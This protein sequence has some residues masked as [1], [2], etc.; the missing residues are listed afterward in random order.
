MVKLAAYGVGRVVEACI[1]LHG[2]GQRHVVLCVE[3]C[4][5]GK[6]VGLSQ[7]LAVG[8]VPR[9]LAHAHHLGAEGMVRVG[10]AHAH[11]VLWGGAVVQLGLS[12]EVKDARLHVQLCLV[13]LSLNLVQ[14]VKSHANLVAVLGVVD[15]CV[16]KHLGRDDVVPPCCRDDVAPLPSQL[17]VAAVVLVVRLVDGEV[18]LVVARVVAQ[19]QAVAVA[20]LMVHLHVQVV[21]V[22]ARPIV[23]VVPFNMGHIPDGRIGDEVRVGASC[24]DVER[25]LAL[26]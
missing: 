22:V 17:A 21:E 20:E 3:L 9:L 23:G 14:F 12:R 13:G 26:P 10:H 5:V 18:Y 6:H 2:I 11:V 7:L 15:R 4:L 25:G 24:R 16:E 8:V 19:V 1:E